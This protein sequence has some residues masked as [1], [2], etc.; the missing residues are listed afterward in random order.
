[1]RFSPVLAATAAVLVASLTAC[2]SSDDSG[3]TSTS[4]A[5]S[6]TTSA[7]AD[8]GCPSTPPDAAAAT[9]WEL[10]G[11]TGSVAVVSPTDSTAPRID[12]VTPFSIADTTV[13]TLEAGDGAVV[14]ETASVSVCYEGVNGRTGEIFDS[15][16]QRGAP[17]QFPLSGVV[18]GFK[19]AIAGQTV[20]SSVA[21]AMTSADGYPDGM[22]AA[23]IEAG[24]T[25]VFVV[26]ILDAG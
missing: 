10:P 2:G 26:Q 14:P 4:D 7:T 19:L 11:A 5:A 6:A 23:G 12:V 16:Y 25:L 17:A 21:V 3:S 15:S 1:M 8:T 13:H 9:A 20:G 18:N 22:P 24:D